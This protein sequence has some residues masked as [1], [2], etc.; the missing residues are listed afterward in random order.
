[1]NDQHFV[2]RCMNG[3]GNRLCNIMNMFYIHD[4][5]PQSKIY[6]DWRKNN[7]C[8]I[9]IE[10]IIDITQYKWLLS[11]DE[12]YDNIFPEYRNIELWASTD[13]NERTRWDKNDEW[14]NHKCIVSVSFNIFEFVTKKYCINIFNSFIFKPAIHE[15]V[16][17][18]IQKYGIDKNIIHFR[19][20]DLLKILEMNGYENEIDKINKKIDIVK[21]KNE[22]MEYNKLDVD[23]K[24]NDVLESVADL[25]FMSKY[26]NLM[27][28]SS[29]SHFSS[30]IFLL[31]RKYVDD[32]N[33]YPIFN[34]RIIDIIVL[35]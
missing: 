12:Y 32:I 6:L 19:N 35:Q 24:Y 28:Y 31:S 29:Y 34:S 30:W 16:N 11:S 2:F 14:K 25:I 1:M 10:D 22:I 3:F 20:G 9:G 17:D 5:Y 26:C 18:K 8:N 7:H 4:K 13:V 33:K 23:R 27:G 21:N 15:I